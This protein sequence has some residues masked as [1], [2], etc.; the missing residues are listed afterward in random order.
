[1]SLGGVLL[2]AKCI[3]AMDEFVSR[4]DG[5]LL[6]LVISIPTKALDPFHRIKK[7]MGP[8]LNLEG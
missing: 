5:S 7:K 4:K 3:Q 1:M 6:E 8:V 2:W